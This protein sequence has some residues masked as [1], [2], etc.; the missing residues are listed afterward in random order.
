M[1]LLNG[2]FLLLNGTYD[3]TAAVTN[4]ETHILTYHQLKNVREVVFLLGLVRLLTGV[5]ACWGPGTTSRQFHVVKWT[6]VCECVFSTY[7][8]RIDGALGCIA[9]AVWLDFC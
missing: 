7:M 8:H 4:L 9:I 3:I 2:V 6:Y 1:R 5:R